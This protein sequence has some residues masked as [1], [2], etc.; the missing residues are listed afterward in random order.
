MNLDYDIEQLYIEGHSP[1]MIA[2]ILDCDVE[3]VYRWIEGV[4]VAA[5]ETE[6]QE[7]YGA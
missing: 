7:Y 6:D 2:K 3:A 5:D 4:N 1:K